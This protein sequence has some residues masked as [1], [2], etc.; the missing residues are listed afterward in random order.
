M[1]A[2]GRAPRQDVY[3]EMHLVERSLRR[4]APAAPALVSPGEAPP[5]QTAA[6]LTPSPATLAVVGPH[7]QWA[8]P[9]VLQVTHQSPPPPPT[10]SRC[11]HTHRVQHNHRTCLCF[12]GMH[13]TSCTPLPTWHLDVDAHVVCAAL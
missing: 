11:A 2:G 3:H 1:Q 9:F 12:H 7:L 8:L 5:S 6:S 10:L 13:P 4:F